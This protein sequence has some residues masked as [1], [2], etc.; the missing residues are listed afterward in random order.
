MGDTRP[1]P[2][3]S[4]IVTLSLSPASVAESKTK[5][6]Q[7]LEKVSVNT[8]N[9]KFIG[10][11]RFI[12]MSFI[13]KV[14][15]LLGITALVSSKLEI[16]GSELDIAEEVSV[17]TKICEDAAKLTHHSD[18]NASL[19]LFVTCL[20]KKLQKL[21]QNDEEIAEVMATLETV[22]NLNIEGHNIVKRETDVSDYYDDDYSSEEMRVREDIDYKEENFE[23][24]GRKLRNKKKKDKKKQKKNRRKWKEVGLEDDNDQE[25]MASKEVVVPVNEISNTEI[26]ENESEEKQTKGQ[27]LQFSAYSGSASQLQYKSKEPELNGIHED[28]D[29]GKR[30]FLYSVDYQVRDDLKTSTTSALAPKEISL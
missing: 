18:P 23:E 30:K 27:V 12:R 16:P 8:C 13:C 4:G 20:L 22:E 25:E 5:L 26:E 14:P 9:A 21:P 15:F 1:L 2:V 11:A 7:L 3:L 10:K 17:D 19:D 24:E 6:A 29:G 28:K